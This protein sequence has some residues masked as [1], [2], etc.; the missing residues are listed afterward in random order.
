[1]VF[2]SFLGFNNNLF[3]FLNSIKQILCY[4]FSWFIE[5]LLTLS[6]PEKWK[7]SIFE[8]PIIPT[9]L[10]INNWITT[11]A[12][13]INLHI[14]RKLIEYFLKNICV[15]AMFTLT[16]FEILLFKGR[17]LLTPAQRGTRSKRV[18]ILV[19]IKKNVLFLLKLLEKWLIYK[20]RRFQMVF[21]FLF[22]FFYSFFFILFNTF[23]EKL[24]FWNSNNSTNF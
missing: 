19:K 13:S 22:F 17:S 24:D 18:Q 12:K 1:M 14:I 21:I 10:N 16:V 6:V 15:K 20:L 11:S 7:N 8:I 5:L 9:S 2:T 3:T 23:V 4:Y